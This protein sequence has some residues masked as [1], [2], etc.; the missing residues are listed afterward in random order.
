VDVRDWL[1]QLIC[2]R[3]WIRLVLFV[4]D[5]PFVPRNQA[6]AH[7]ATAMHVAGQW[8]VDTLI[9]AHVCGAAF[10]LIVQRDR[11]LHRMLP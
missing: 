3:A 5:T 4:S 2:R 7:I 11:V 9:A 8:A 10:H 6:L 1:Y